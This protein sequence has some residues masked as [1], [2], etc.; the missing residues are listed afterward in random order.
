MWSW[1]GPEG[2]TLN[3][4][5]RA[6]GFSVA[7]NSPIS[8]ADCKGVSMQSQRGVILALSICGSWEEQTQLIHY[9]HA[10]L[11]ACC[12]LSSSHW[13]PSGAP[14]PTPIPM[15]DRFW[16]DS[17]GC[18]DVL[19]RYRSEAKNCTFPQEALVCVHVYVCAHTHIE[20]CDQQNSMP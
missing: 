5:W 9:F 6:L 14:L 17:T 1:D 4:S 15:G 12:I 19:A 3:G 7:L 10:S 20:A 13:R 8:S 18:S 2:L 16:K 11:Q